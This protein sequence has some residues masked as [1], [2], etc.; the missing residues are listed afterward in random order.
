MNIYHY[1]CIC[2]AKKAE[3]GGTKALMKIMGGVVEGA[4]KGEDVWV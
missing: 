3:R 2:I 4:M 1:L